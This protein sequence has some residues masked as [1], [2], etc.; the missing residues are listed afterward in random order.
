[1]VK[2]ALEMKTN[3]T[4]EKAEWMY[5]KM[6]EIRTFEDR[7]HEIFAQGKASRLCSLIC[8]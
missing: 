2:T 4:M 3:I 6:L 8:W 7:V 5:R 1:M